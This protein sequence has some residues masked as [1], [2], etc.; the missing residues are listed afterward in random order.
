VLSFNAPFWHPS[1]SP[2]GIY[3]P[4]GSSLQ[5]TLSRSSEDYSS[6]TAR[7]IFAV[8]DLAAANAYV[9]VAGQPGADADGLGIFAYTGSQVAGA[10]IQATSQFLNGTLS[11]GK[12]LVCL[13]RYIPDDTREWRIRWTGS[14]GWQAL[15][16]LSGVTDFTVDTLLAVSDGLFETSN[17]GLMEVWFN[18]NEMDTVTIDGVKD[19]YQAQ[20]DVGVGW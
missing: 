7:T 10:S 3:D 19:F 4:T 6:F 5:L 11:S 9:G 17:G 18:S 1:A 2:A 15:P 13:S 16:N 8:V 12:K 20:A 14:G